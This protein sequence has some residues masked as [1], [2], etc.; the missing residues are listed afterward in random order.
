MKTGITKEIIDLFLKELGETESFTESEIEKIRIHA[1]RDELSSK[2]IM[3]KL[4]NSSTLL[5]E[6]NET[7]NPENK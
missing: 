3:E 1:T 4:I 5:I 2:S 7:Q 6:K